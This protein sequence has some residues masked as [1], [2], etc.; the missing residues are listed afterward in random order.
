MTEHQLSRRYEGRNEQSTIQPVCSCGWIGD[1]V[2]AWNDYQ[3]AVIQE[4]ERNHLT[5][6]GF[7][8]S[9]GNPR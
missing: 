1:P 3:H 8:G 2:P 9:T 4:Q 6:I 5:D 7:K